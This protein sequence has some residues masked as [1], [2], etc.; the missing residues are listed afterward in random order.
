MDGAPLVV[1]QQCYV[2]NAQSVLNCYLLI[3]QLG[4]LPLP[5]PP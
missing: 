5:V 3:G 1:Q 4:K 2:N